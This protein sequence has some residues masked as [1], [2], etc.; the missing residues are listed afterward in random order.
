MKA[1]LIFALVDI[2]L[3]L[4]YVVAYVRSIIRRLFRPC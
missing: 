3:F 4:A 1:L 2:L